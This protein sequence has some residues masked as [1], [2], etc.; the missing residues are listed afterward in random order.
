LDLADEIIETLGGK[1]RAACCHLIEDTAKCPAVRLKAV[2]ALICEQFW[3]HIIRSA[4]FLISFQIGCI[5]TFALGC[6]LQVR[7][8]ACQPEVT[9]L[10]SVVLVDQDVG[11][12][13]VTV[14]DA[15]R[16]QV[17]KALG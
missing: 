3:R 7:K 5:L 12:L 2:H 8:L 4:T 14:N 16:M 15:V 10:E 9:E 13:E 1:G 6:C 11:R 17:I